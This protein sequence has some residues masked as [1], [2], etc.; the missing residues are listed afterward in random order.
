MS[1]MSDGKLDEAIKLFGEAVEC[2]PHSAVLFAKRA[3]TLVSGMLRY[4]R[5]VTLYNVRYAI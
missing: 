3:Q 4:I 2:N 5:Y 1:A